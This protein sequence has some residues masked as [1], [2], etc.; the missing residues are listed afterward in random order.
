MSLNALGKTISIPGG[1]VLVE[2]ILFGWECPSE[3][4]YFVVTGIY[5]KQSISKKA[6]NQLTSAISIDVNINLDLKPYQ[7]RKEIDKLIGAVSCS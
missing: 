3:D 6:T 1:S 7:E 5:P 4:N 2:I